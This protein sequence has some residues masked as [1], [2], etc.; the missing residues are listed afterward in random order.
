M[1]WDFQSIVRSINIE[2]VVEFT[3]VKERGEK[4]YI[5]KVYIEISKVKG[6]IIFML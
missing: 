5:N 2:N 6:Y 1:V 3:G 4:V